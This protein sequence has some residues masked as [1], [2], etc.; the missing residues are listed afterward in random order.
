MKRGGLRILDTT[1][2]DGDQSPLG[3]FTGEEKLAIARSLSDS[4]VDVIEAGFPASGTRDFDACALVA[5]ASRDFP[6]TPAIALMARAKKEDID[7]AARALDGHP[8]GIIHLTLPASDRHIA[9]KLRLDREALLTLAREATARAR[10]A[11]YAVE[12]GAEDATRADPEFLAAFAQVVTESGAETVNV[13]DTLGIALPREIAGLVAFL[14]DRVPA[15]REGKAT[16]SVHCHNDS[17]LA[18]ANTLAAIEAGAGQAEVTVLGLGERAGNAALEELAA[19]MSTH[20]E[21][22]PRENPLDRDALTRASRLVASFAGTGLS[23][24]KPVTGW[25]VRAHAS[26][27][28]Q[29]GLSRDEATYRSVYGPTGKDRIVLTRHSGRA[30]VIAYI[31]RYLALGPDGIPDSAIIDRILEALKGENPPAGLTEILALAQVPGLLIPESFSF[32]GGETGYKAEARFPGKHT[33]RAEGP[34]REATLIALARSASGEPVTL[35]S[36]SLTGFGAISEN[37]MTLRIH[38]EIA[39]EGRPETF[40]EI[41]RSGTDLPLLIFSALLD[42]VNAARS[43]GAAGATTPR[44]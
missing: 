4:G 44:A 42:C 41:D 13:A 34:T 33:I 40:C 10:D 1:L 11:G 5:R 28:H 2:R 3:G 43:A 31:S 17:G 36:V 37:T 20:P 32:S 16:V 22:Y 38:A 29:Q 12:F 26:G 9:A 7:L 6:E 35:H 15:F 14:I 25:N 19:I 24:L 39:I 21:R 18:L 23:P 30:G 27:I 8:R